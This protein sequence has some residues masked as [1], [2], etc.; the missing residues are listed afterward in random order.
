MSDA[1][2]TITKKHQAALSF[3]ENVTA[4]ANEVQHQVLGE[5][6]RR[7]ASAEYLQRH[8]VTGSC[9]GEHETFRRLI[10]IVT[11]E[12]IKP[13][14]LRIANGG[15]RKLIPSTSDD[16]D[17]RFVL[18]G[19][20]VPV[21]S[22]FI[23]SIESGKKMLLLFAKSQ[24]CTAGGIPA[25]TV[26][27]SVYNSRHFVER[28]PDLYTS[29]TEAILCPDLKQSM[30]AQL[31][32]GI[33]KS[34]EVVVVGSIFA[35]GFTRAINFLEKYW[36]RFCRDIRNGELDREVTDP[37]IRDAVN[38]ILRPD[39]ALAERVEEACRRKSWQGII[40][41][42]WPNAKYI[43]VVATGTMAQYVPILEFYGDG[44]PLVCSSYASSECSFG[45]NLNPICKPSEVAYTLIPTMAY[46]EFLPVDAD[47][48]CLVNLI[49]VKV[50]EEYEI[51]VTTHSGLYRYRV[52][53]VLRVTGFKNRTP[54]FS[55]VRRKDVVLS[56]DTDKTDELEL[57][58]AVERA[59][60][61][62]RPYG[63]TVAEHTS[64]ADVTT[65]PGH[66]VLY[67]ELR[68]GAEEVPASV[69]DDCCL[70]VEESLNG[71]Y[72]QCRTAEGSIGPLEIKL[73]EEGTFDRL[74]DF[75]ISQGASMDQYKVPKCLR[76]GPMVELMERSVKARFFSPKCPTWTSSM[77]L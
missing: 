68:G 7:N 72:R 4:N 25:R 60:G 77:I 56:I 34:A 59:F 40:R 43:E 74:M 22:Q 24:T 19:L 44:L 75:A 65:I 20:L 76:P 13:D 15:E 9:A 73:V 47:D 16:F 46:F 8:G 69:F 48:N 2:D 29:P 39:P 58:T 61:G 14:I 3:I 36:P 67:W 18:Y 21:M 32:C 31:L 6:L 5:I 41:D 17:R 38:R 27:T 45:I 1:L 33:V 37:A 12:D 49:D 62:L 63:V 42:L 64:F 66:Y 54:Q 52:G 28:A 26:L 11:Y 71:V 70:V 55:F 35:S 53:D 23:P 57:Q 51:V 10:P 50:G 30:Y